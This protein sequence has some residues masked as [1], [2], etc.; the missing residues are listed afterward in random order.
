MYFK[1]KNICYIISLLVCGGY[2]NAE[3]FNINALNLSVDDNIDLSYFEKNNFS[4]GLYETDIVLNGK[5]ILR[6]EKIKFISHDGI[7]EPCIT[8][9]V[10]KRFPLTEDAKE[11]LLSSEE[12]H[13]IN[14]S[15]LD[16]NVTVDFNDSDQVLTI[17]IPQKYLVAVYSSWISPELRDYGIAGLILDYT[18]SDNNFYRKDSG[19]RNNLSAFGNVGANLAEWRLRANYQYENKLVDSSNDKK[20]R[21]EWEQIYAFRDMASLSAKLFVGEIYIKSDLFDSVRFKG[22]SVFTDESMMPPNLRGYAPQITGVAASNATVTLSQN[23]RIISQIK[24][25]A[26]PFVIKDLSQSVMGT[27]DVT[28]IEDNGKETRFQYTTTN[29]PF[30]TRKGQVRYTMNLGQLSPENNENIDKNFITVESSIGVLNNTSVF[31]GLVATSNNQYRAINLGVGQ[32]LGFLGALSVDVTQ[33]YAD[34]G[35]RE[36]GKSY[37]INY[38]KN[39][40]SIDGQLTLTGYRFADRTFN[41]LSNFVEKNFSDN[42]QGELDKDKHVFSLSYAQQLHFMNASAN[43]TA[44]RKTYWNGKQNNYFSIGLNKFFDEGIMKGG[45]VSLSL[46]QSRN[47]RDK[48]DNQIYLSVSRPL[49]TESQNASISYFASYSDQ[50]K[51]YTNNVNY[52]NY[53]NKDTNYNLTASTQDGL[54]QGS[55]N[56]F[57]SHSGDTGQLQMSGALSDSMNSASIMVSGSITATQHGI[58][59]HRLTYRDQSR[60]V[61]DVPKAKG[62]IIENSH[63]ITNDLGLAT[64]SNVPTYYNMEYKVDVNNLPDTVNVEDNVLETALTDGAIGYIKMDAD[65][66][67]SL[68]S[69]IKLANGQYPPLGAVVTNTSNNKVSG[70]IAESGIVYLT[71]LNMGD[72]LS[73]NWGEGKSCSFSAD[74]I[75]V[76][77]SDAIM[78]N[79]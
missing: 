46:N 8:A 26:G 30:L 70:I 2:S 29:I 6:G 54:S 65:I 43:I 56:A 67:K 49:Q 12:D 42:S 77:S 72:Q 68:I 7:I 9:S 19:N 28:V 18:V 57:I 58:S 63:A 10:I 75:L 61:V 76:K 1:K 16:K 47:S 69:R 64:I 34:V 35:T 11:I 36:T 66:G 14:I 37:R 27:I 38:A 41:S 39:L 52:S 25:P 55:V 15:A 44:S 24:V 74:S 59:A 62:V 23:G 32:N 73:I 5:R 51:R 3:T 22:I 13:C 33:S 20:S 78:C 45:S 40:P 21:F 17:S 60:L 31:G 53:V 4:E 48:T 50:D 71:G 79:Q